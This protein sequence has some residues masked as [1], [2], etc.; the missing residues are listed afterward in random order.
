MVVVDKERIERGGWSTTGLLRARTARG[1][2]QCEL[3][4]EVGG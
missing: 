2:D 4:M 1:G 3:G